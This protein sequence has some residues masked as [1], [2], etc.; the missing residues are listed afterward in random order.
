MR[1]LR[2]AGTF[3]LLGALVA[4]IYACQPAPPDTRA[5]DERAIRDADTAWLKAAQAKDCAGWVSFFSDDASWLPANAPILTGKQAISG[6]CSQ[7]VANPGFAISWQATKVEVS[8][9]SDL[10][11]AIGTYELTLNDPKGKPVTDRGKWVAVWKK[12]PNSTWK[13]AADIF[14]S[15]Q[16]LPAPP[17]R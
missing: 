14:N 11:Y 17:R 13:V 10:A 5:T 9:A 6:Y 1:R 4:L 15:D 12:Q 16:P 2:F 3:A 8:R 7:M